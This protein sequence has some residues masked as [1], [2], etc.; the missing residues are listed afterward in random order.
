MLFLVL[1]AT[2]FV[3]VVTGSFV[4]GKFLEHVSKCDAEDAVSALQ[5][6]VLIRRKSAAHLLYSPCPEACTPAECGTPNEADL[7]KPIS[8]VLQEHPELDGFCYFSQFY[9]WWLSDVKSTLK[10]RNMAPV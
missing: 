5:T 4:E 9:A 6:S 3:G 7:D 1:L 2:H 10:A 8:Q